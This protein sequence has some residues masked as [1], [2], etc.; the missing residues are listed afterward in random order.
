[1]SFMMFMRLLDQPKS[2]PFT[3]SA[4]RGRQIFEDIGCDGCHTPTMHTKAGDLGT[5]VPQ[6]RDV[7]VNLFSDVLLHNMGARLA[8][9]VIQGNAGPDMF[10]TAPLWGI[11]QR[12]F[13]LHD[14]RSNTLD[15][16]ILQHYS[17]AT[18]ANGRNP[19][20]GPSEANQ[21]ILKFGDLHA[22]SQQDV[23]NFLRRL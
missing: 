18:P 7:D 20:Y 6:L 23:L 1:M 12:L 3:A 16:A 10:R 11:G 22:Q 15:D 19:A 5:F 8:D 2:A 13:F 9:N 21:V 17:A 14:G 4:Q